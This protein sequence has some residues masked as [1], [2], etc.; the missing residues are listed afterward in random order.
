MP[1]LHRAKVASLPTLLTLGAA[2]PHPYSCQELRPPSSPSPAPSAYKTQDSPSPFSFSQRHGERPAPP[3][4]PAMPLPLTSRKT[5][6][7][8]PLEVAGSPHHRRRPPHASPCWPLLRPLHRVGASE[9]PHPQELARRIAPSSVTPPHL[10]RRPEC[11]RRVM[12]CA[13]TARGR[14]HVT[15]RL[16]PA[17]PKWPLGRARAKR[18]WDK[19][20][21]S[22]VHSLIFSFSNLNSRKLL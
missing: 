12:W 17:K 16:G 18:H 15:L 19:Y 7:H 20:R 4:W 13:V 11:H 2:H 10:P 3:H 6:P 21:P 1:L 22:A 8:W 14:T 9:S 5:E